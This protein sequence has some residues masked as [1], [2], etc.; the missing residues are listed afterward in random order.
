MDERGMESSDTYAMPDEYDG[1]DQGGQGK[2]FAVLEQR[3]QK[4]YDEQWQP[5]EQ[6]Q[7][8]DAT[9]ARGVHKYGAQKGRKEEKEKSQFDIILEDGIQFAEPEVVGG[10]FKMPEISSKAH[11]ESDD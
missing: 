1:S 5:N 3:Y 6:Q 9:V 10:N 7:L 8:E 4:T 11:A 2:R